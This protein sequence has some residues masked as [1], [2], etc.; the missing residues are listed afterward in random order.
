MLGRVNLLECGSVKSSHQ[1]AHAKVN[2]NSGIAGRKRLRAGALELRRKHPT[3]AIAPNASRK[4]ATFR[5]I[6]AAKA[7]ASDL[8]HPR[9]VPCDRS[10]LPE[11]IDAA[12][13]DEFLLGP[14]KIATVARPCARSPCAAAPRPSAPRYQ[15]RHGPEAPPA[16]PFRLVASCRRRSAAT[17]CAR[18]ICLWPDIR[19]SPAQ[20]AGSRGSEATRPIG[21]NGKLARAWDRAA[22][23]S[24]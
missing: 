12:V 11:A 23:A 7:D 5:Q 15:A 1:R 19:P 20:A 24:R 16:I 3:L 6:A 2:A 4:Q 8:G 18:E 9:L 17:A 10:R 13:V 22:P 14:G 21:S